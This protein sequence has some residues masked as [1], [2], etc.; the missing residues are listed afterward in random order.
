MNQST[1]AYVIVMVVLNWMRLDL[2][3]MEV[4]MKD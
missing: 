4:L 2:S 3:M 1:V